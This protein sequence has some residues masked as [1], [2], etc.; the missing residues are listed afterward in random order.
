MIGVGVDQPNIWSGESNEIDS[1]IKIDFVFK[2]KD[3]I[4]GSDDDTDIEYMYQYLISNNSH[5]L[6]DLQIKEGWLNHIKH[7]EE[8]YLVGF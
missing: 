5:I 7:N 8:N 3:E 6:T 1:L 2:N 4:W